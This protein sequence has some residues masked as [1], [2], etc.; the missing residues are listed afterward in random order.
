MA[1]PA[2]PGCE[3]SP[4]PGARA[5]SSRLLVLCL[6]FT[7]ICLMASYT[8][9]LTAFLGIKHV[10]VP[11]YGMQGL[12]QSEIHGL[13]VLGGSSS[14]AYFGVSFQQS[15]NFTSLQNDTENVDT[16]NT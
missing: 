1:F 13:G 9:Q 5:A 3:G 11:F 10:H 16:F 7:A 6:H 4:R 12:L 8:G 14:H 2:A 15:D